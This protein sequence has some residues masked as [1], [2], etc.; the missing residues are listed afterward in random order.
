MLLFQSISSSSFPVSSSQM[1]IRSCMCAQHVLPYLIF[2][3]YHFNLFLCGSTFY[4][5]PQIST[6]LFNPSHP[7]SQSIGQVFIFTFV[8]LIF[9]VIFII[10]WPIFS[11]AISSCMDVQYFLDSLG[12]AIK[13]LFFEKSSYIF[14]IACFVLLFLCI[15]KKMMLLVFFC[16][17]DIFGHSSIII[18]EGPGLLTR[19]TGVSIFLGQQGLY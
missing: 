13:C 14:W 7:M 15:L 19:I 10:F 18:I 8:S 12:M 2:S 11:L 5:T 9:S 1:F 16:S 3:L 4:F 6:L 17:H